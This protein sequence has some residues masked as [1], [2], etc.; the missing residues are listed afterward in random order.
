MT[1]TIKQLPEKYLGKGTVVNPEYAALWG[2]HLDEG[3]GYKHVAEIFGVHKHTVRKYYPGRGW[4]QRQAAELG[5]YM[6][7]H[8]E[9]M[10]KVPL[11]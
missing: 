10:R 5:T 6:K 4:T 9:R 8:N 7:H 1:S 3:M 11:G 2:P